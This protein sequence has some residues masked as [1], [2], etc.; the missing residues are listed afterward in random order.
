[1]FNWL[2]AQTPVF[3]IAGCL[4]LWG[5]RRLKGAKRTPPSSFS[6]SSRP[7]L[8]T[9]GKEADC[10]SARNVFFHPFPRLLHLVHKPLH[11]FHYCAAIPTP[12]GDLPHSF[13]KYGLTI[14][15]H[16]WYTSGFS[17]ILLFSYTELFTLGLG[18]SVVLKA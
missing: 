12:T 1:M 4:L 5:R 11:A 16:T 14:A 17:L 18:N 3:L 2:R 9:I 7:A 15:C 8:D 13:L 6:E 10:I